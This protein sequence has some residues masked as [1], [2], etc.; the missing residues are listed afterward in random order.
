MLLRTRV[1]SR[2]R[3]SG[4][5]RGTIARGATVLY[6][7]ESRGRANGFGARVNAASVA[8]RLI[9]LAIAVSLAANLYWLG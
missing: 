6:G 1:A 7:A 5:S 3:I 2:V 9:L 4:G 8:T